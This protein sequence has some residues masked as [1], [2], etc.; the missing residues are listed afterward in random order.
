MSERATYSS[1]IDPKTFNWE[2][3]HHHLYIQSSDS[4]LRDMV[5]T[6]VNKGHRVVVEMGCGPARL[7]ERLV[8][9]RG[10]SYTGVDHDATFI[11]YAKKWLP[12]NTFHQ[13]DAETYCHPELADVFLSQGMH[14]HIPKGEAVQQYL[15]N[16]R[17]N[18]RPGG[19]YIV[20]D[21]FLAE[22]DTNNPMGRLVQ[23]VIWHSHII[24]H[25]LDHGH[26][27]LAV[28]EAKTLLDDTAGGHD[29]NIK[30]EKQIKDVLRVVRA[31][32]KNALR[33]DRVT[34]EVLSTG[35]LE[36]LAKEQVDHPSG[37][38]RLDLSRGDF[39]VCGSIF[40][41]EAAQAGFQVIA[42]KHVGPI[43]HIGGFSIYTL[44]KP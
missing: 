7:A 31:I 11:D 32:D 27:V 44:L 5:E 30:S 43:K 4:I 33:H 38:P 6:E 42:T 40:Q 20:S 29:T 13:D 26:E 41:K 17:N 39:K 8:T 18:L 21:E 24:A 37:D 10:I 14:H 2:M 9:I 25:A 3:T 34:A 16:I 1:I 28:E 36:L 19:I 15:A 23:T 22:Y 35:L 12:G